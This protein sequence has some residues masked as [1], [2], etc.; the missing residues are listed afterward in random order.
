MTLRKF[1]NDNSV[2]Y[3]AKCEQTREIQ[4]NTLKNKSTHRKQKK[5][6]SQNDWKIPKKCGSKW[7]YLLCLNIGLLLLIEKQRDML[8]EHTKTKPQ[9][10]LE[11][12][13]NELLQTFPFDTPINLVKKG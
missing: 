8:I 7:I 9:E 6:I 12:K 3:I 13:M 5:S 11:F 1:T 2:R 10:I 4:Q